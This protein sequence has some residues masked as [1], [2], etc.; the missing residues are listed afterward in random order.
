M[1]AL[2]GYTAVL[3]DASPYRLRYLLTCTGVGGASTIIPNALGATPD[4]RT[5]ALGAASF[6]TLGLPILKAMQVTLDTS[7]GAQAAQV[8]ARNL[9]L[10]GPIKVTITPRS[11]VG[12]VGV[13][14]MV[15][16]DANEGAAAGDPPSAGYFV[17]LLAALGQ[18]RG[19]AGETLYLDIKLRHTIDDGGVKVDDDTTRPV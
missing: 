3:V 15:A 8:Q 18:G 5:D 13:P 4:L 1:G 17:Y 9:L 10:E 19:H 11:G 16:V 7:V 2:P 6:G 12:G 14:D